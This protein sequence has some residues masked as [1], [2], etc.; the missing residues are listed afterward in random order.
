MS[1]VPYDYDGWF[2]DDFFDLIIDETEEGWIVDYPDTDGNGLADF[3]DEWIGN[4]DIEL[5]PSQDH[6]GV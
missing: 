2:P 3:C 4:P 5:R 6:A 1:F